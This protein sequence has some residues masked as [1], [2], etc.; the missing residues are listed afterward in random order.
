M[1]EMAMS[2]AIEGKH[3]QTAS[4]HGNSVAA[5]RLGYA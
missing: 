1:T 4:G 2:T 5:I 3:G